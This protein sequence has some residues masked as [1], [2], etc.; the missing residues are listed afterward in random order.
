MKLQKV[1]SG[2]LAFSMMATMVPCDVSAQTNL[3]EKKSSK[4]LTGQSE[5]QKKVEE[6]KNK[7]KERK[8]V[9]GEILLVSKAGKSKKE[10]TQAIN[11]VR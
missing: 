4:V 6:L 3:Q 5:L 8:Y 1:V 11:A 10:N 2:L 9:E 7:K